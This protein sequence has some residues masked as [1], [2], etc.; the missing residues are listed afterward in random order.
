MA[1]TSIRVSETPLVLYCLRRADDALVMGHRLSEWTGRGPALEEEMALAN[2][3]LDLLG[4]A[5]SL[6]SYAAEVEGAG[7]DE[8]GYAYLRDSRQYRNLLLAEQP[9]GD[10][11]RTMLRQFFYAAFADPYWRAMMNSSDATLAAIAAKSEKESAYHLR[12]TAEWVIRLGDGTEE[13]H[14]R[15][16]EAVA[17]LWPYTG[18]MFEADAAEQELIQAGIVLDPASFRAQWEKTVSEVLAEATLEKP[19][20]TWM[21]KGGRSGI[22]SEHLGHMLAEMQ[23]L[24]RTYPGATW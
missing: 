4:Q 12:H 19:A 24:A 6:Y 11:A 16:A 23:V 2:I 21:Q 1:T 13:S 7:H 14:R 22:H 10:F 18:E 3:G 15:A 17:H 20:G 8:D 5:R 9:N